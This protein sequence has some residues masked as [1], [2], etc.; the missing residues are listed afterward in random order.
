MTSN[1]RFTARRATGLNGTIIKQRQITL[2]VR[3]RGGATTTLTL[4]RPLTAQQLRATHD[5][6]RRQIDAL[7]DDYTDAQVAHVLNERALL[8]GAGDAFDETSVQWVRFAHKLKS[9]KQRLL[10]SGWLTSRQMSSRLGVARTTLARW[11]Q[12]GRIQARICNDN[13]EWLYR[14][15]SLEDTCATSTTDSSTARGAV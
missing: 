6:V 15:P 7:L 2:A 11:R 4:P 1:D 3:F 14:P 10:D 13:G 8:T 5:D 9:L 12:T